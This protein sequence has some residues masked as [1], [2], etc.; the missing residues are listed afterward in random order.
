M[1]ILSLVLFPLRINLLGMCSPP[2]VDSS[3]L[4]VVVLPNKQG[5]EDQPNDVIKQEGHDM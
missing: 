2:I 1:T 3:V 4:I 5:E